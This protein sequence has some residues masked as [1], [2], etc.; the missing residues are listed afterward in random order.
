[1][2]HEYLVVWKG[3][4]SVNNSWEPSASLSNC[5]EIVTK[6]NKG[7]ELPDEVNS[8]T[9]KCFMDKK[10]EKPIFRTCL[11]FFKE[12]QRDFF[13]CC[14]SANVVSSEKPM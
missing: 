7:K 14:K 5:P 6:Y 13:K 12:S 8:K 4:S 9:W 3:Y 10:T 2:L 1:M 11:F